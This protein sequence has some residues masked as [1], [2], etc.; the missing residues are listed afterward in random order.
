MHYGL[1]NEPA[2]YLCT[3]IQ[4]PEGINNLWKSK[5]GEYMVL[6]ENDFIRE[7]CVLYLNK[8]NSCVYQ[9]RQINNARINNRKIL[10]TIL[11]LSQP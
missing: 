1:M 9:R 4:F 8:N 5:S 11:C 3:E 2:H 10:S 6:I 7:T